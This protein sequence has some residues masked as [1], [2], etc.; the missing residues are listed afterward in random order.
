[1]PS[2]QNCATLLWFFWDAKCC[3]SWIKWSQK[4]HSNFAISWHIVLLD[5]FQDTFYQVYNLLLE[6][7]HWVRIELEIDLTHLIK[8]K[9]HNQDSTNWICSRQQPK[10]FWTSWGWTR[11]CFPS[12]LIRVLKMPFFLKDPADT[13]WKHLLTKRGIKEHKV[14]QSPL[15]QGWGTQGPLALLVVSDGWDEESTL[16]LQCEDGGFH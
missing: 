8:T 6:Y 7:F 13:F 1:M 11:S 4:V 3:W 9:L 14:R 12:R 5:T 2:P 16:A 15:V 10:Y